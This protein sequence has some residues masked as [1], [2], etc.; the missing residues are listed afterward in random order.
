MPVRFSRSDSRENRYKT[1]QHVVMAIAIDKH[2]LPRSVRRFGKAR[3][4]EVGV[5]MC[6]CRTRRCRASADR[7]IRRRAG[8][9]YRNSQGMVL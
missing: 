3:C 6:K 2:G 7:N 9:N 1:I 5:A 8:I 4:V